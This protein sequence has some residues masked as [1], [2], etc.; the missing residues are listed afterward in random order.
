MIVSVLVLALAA[1]GAPKNPGGISD[2]GGFDPELMEQYLRNAY[3]GNVV[4][5][6]YAINHKG[7]L[8]RSGAWGL[9]RRAVDGEQAMAADT[10]QLLASVSK[11]VNAIFFLQAM[12]RINDALGYVYVDLDSPVAPW[13][14]DAWT[15]GPGFTGGNPLTFR[16]LLAHT[17]GFGQ[18]FDGLTDAEKALWGNG[19]SGLEYVVGLGAMPGSPR[20]YKNANPALFRILIPRL[21]QKAGLSPFEVNE[22]T[23]G[24]LY[25]AMLNEQ[26]LLPLGIGRVE[27]SFQSAGNYALYY[28]FENPA[29]PGTDASRALKDCGG[30]SGLFMS[31]V[32]LAKL[33]AYARYDDGILDDEARDRMAQQALGWYNRVSTGDPDTARLR[34]RGDYYSWYVDKET[35]PWLAN[36]QHTC[37]IWYP[38]QVEAVLLVNSSVGNGAPMPCDLLDQAYQAAV[39]GP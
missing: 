6:S 33:L 31:A 5:F 27:C 35:Y 34:K 23:A 18:I 24:A 30:H 2:K 3:E 32:E 19:W 26:I 7:K 13:L 12:R 22:N 16:H 38:R 21:F 17:S 8:A 4:G 11:T 14:P 9:A 37:A 20:D 10:R 25:V 15:A 1:C 39:A 29:Q 28:D 36:E